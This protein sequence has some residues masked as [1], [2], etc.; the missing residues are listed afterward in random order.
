MVTMTALAL[1]SGC[2][3]TPVAPT[4]DRLA[5]CAKACKMS[6][7]KTYTD[8]NITCECQGK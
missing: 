5:V 8:E 6:G 3:T 7:L 4:P 2:A 1:L